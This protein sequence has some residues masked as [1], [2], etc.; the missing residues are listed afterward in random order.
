[1]SGIN[2][3]VI[4]VLMSRTRLQRITGHKKKTEEGAASSKAFQRVT[5]ICPTSTIS[6]A[7]TRNTSIGTS[8]N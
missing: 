5:K 2:L 4:L 6:R 8:K 3:C 1:L 7:S